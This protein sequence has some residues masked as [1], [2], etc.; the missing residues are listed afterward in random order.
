MMLSGSPGVQLNAVDVFRAVQPLVAGDNIVTHNLGSAAVEVEVRDAV[1]GG[2]VS[3]RTKN[4]SS[5]SITLVA[6][7]P[8]SSVRISIDA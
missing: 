4:E 6:A 2:L 3:L 1:T 7:V 8:M 5:T